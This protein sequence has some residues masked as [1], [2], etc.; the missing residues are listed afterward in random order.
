[1]EALESALKTQMNHSTSERR[2]PMPS[3]NGGNTR[4]GTRNRNQDQRTFYLC[5]QERHI[6]RDCT[7]QDQLDRLVGTHQLPVQQPVVN[8]SLHVEGLMGQTSIRF[9]FWTQVLLYLSSV[10]MRWTMVGAN[11]SV[12]QECSS[13]WSSF[14]HVKIRESSGQSRSSQL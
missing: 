8:S 9:F 7:T 3:D 2:T 1:M 12:R 11:A 6:R 14:G 13:G 5:G 10:A 4:S